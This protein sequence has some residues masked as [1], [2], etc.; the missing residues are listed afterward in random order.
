MIHVKHIFSFNRQAYSMAWVIDNSAPFELRLSPSPCF[1]N[2]TTDVANM[3][4]G[5]KKLWGFYWAMDTV[6]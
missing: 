6:G 3:V 2:F 4:R 5:L 1:N